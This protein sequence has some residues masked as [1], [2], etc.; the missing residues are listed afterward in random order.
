MEVYYKQDTGL[1]NPQ[2]RNLDYFVINLIG[3]DYSSSSCGAEVLFY[4][5]LADAQSGTIAPASRSMLWQPLIDSVSQM[6][7]DLFSFDSIDTTSGDTI[8]L[9]NPT[10]E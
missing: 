2:G 6:Q 4:E 1:Q 7:T 9:L 8:T 10:K 5:F 3:A